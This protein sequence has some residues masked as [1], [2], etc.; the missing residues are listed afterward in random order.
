MPEKKQTES[1]RRWREEQQAKAK[2]RAELSN[3]ETEARARRQMERNK[4]MVEAGETFRSQRSPERFRR[5]GH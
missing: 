2:L 3:P 1:R 5:R 4:G